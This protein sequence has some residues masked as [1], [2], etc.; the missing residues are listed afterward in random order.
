M[1]HLYQVHLSPL[2]GA[3]QPFAVILGH[4]PEEVIVHIVEA[5]ALTWEK[6]HIKALVGADEGIDDTYGIRRV[7]IVVDVAGTEGKVSLET[8]SN[9]RIGFKRLYEGGV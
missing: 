8:G 6:K 3:E 5:V 2:A 7:H 9:L 1:V 4:L